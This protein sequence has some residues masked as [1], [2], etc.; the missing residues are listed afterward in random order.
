MEN[1]CATTDRK[2]WSKKILSISDEAFI[3]LCLINY[4]KRWF[5]ELVKTEKMPPLYTFS[6]NKGAH[7]NGGGCGWS[8][9]GMRKY[10]ELY[11]AIKNDRKKSAQTFNQELLKMFLSR[12]KKESGQGVRKQFDDK[13]KKRPHKRMDVFDDNSDEEDDNYSRHLA[14]ELVYSEVKVEAV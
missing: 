14:S 11:M 12:R 8:Q 7:D 13:G 2:V 3:L 4:G 1:H 5:A 9:A 10:D 6:R